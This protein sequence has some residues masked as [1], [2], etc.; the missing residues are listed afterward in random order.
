[1][2]GENV[3]HTIFTTIKTNRNMKY[4]DK[5]YSNRQI[6]LGLVSSCQKNDRYGLLYGIRNPPYNG[7]EQIYE[8]KLFYFEKDEKLEIAQNTLVPYLSYDYNG[9]TP[10]VEYV[11]PVSS[12]VVHKDARGT[13]RADDVYH[14]DETWRLINEGIPYFDYEPSRNYCIYYPMIND[15]DCTIWRGLFGCG[16]YMRKEAVI[17]EIYK[18]L[19]SLE[20][21]GW[22]TLEETTNAIM[23]FKEQ[24]DSINAFEIIDT[25]QIMKICRYV[26]RPGRDDHYFE[27][28]YQCL[29]NED[30]FL[31]Y[32]LPT[33][34]ENVFFDDNAYRS[35]GYKDDVQLLNEETKQA[36]EKAKTEYS[37]EKH[38][39]FLINDY[40]SE[41][42]NDIERAE[43]LI[44]RIQEEFDVDNA[45]EI[46]SQFKGKITDEF[47]SLVN[48]YNESTVIGPLELKKN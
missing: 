7:K 24:I 21:T 28:L 17:Y 4:I 23:K 48:E 36:R 42:Q 35:D 33:K 46:A 31:S 43:L 6:H 8:N 41:V 22:P 30:K 44:N 12:L 15:N 32:L 13:R 27:D 3:E 10:Q 25:F 20:H 39:A 16:I 37:K 11:Y 40:F 5:S 1:M 29:P 34:Q 14:D 9:F 38:L 19:N 47:I 26:S 18:E 45:S 2:C